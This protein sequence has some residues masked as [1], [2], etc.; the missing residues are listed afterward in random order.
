MLWHKLL[1]IGIKRTYLNAIK[2]LY[3]AT[4]G[5]VKLGHYITDISPVKYGVKQGCKMSPTLYSVYINDLADVIRALHAGVELDELNISI[6]NYADDVPLIAPD[7]QHL[8]KMLD[9]ILIP[10]LGCTNLI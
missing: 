1:Q 5:A 7:E 8:Q 3:N 4:Q 9:Y 2:S 10:G 6:L